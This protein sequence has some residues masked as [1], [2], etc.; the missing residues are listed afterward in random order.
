[1]KSIPYINEYREMVTQLVLENRGCLSASEETQQYTTL[2]KCDYYLDRTPETCF[3]ALDDDGRLAG[4]L[5]GCP[6]MDDYELVFT[7]EYLPKAAALSVRRYVEAKLGL[8]PYGMFRDDFK[9]HFTVYVKSAWVGMGVE[10]L[11]VTAV[12]AKLREKHV[13]GVVTVFEADNEELTKLLKQKGFKDQLT[14]KFGHAMT[15]SLKEPAV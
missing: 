7:D 6:D 12:L 5:L 2:T 3:L 4:C 10:D 1:M 11:L 15:L 14:T 13:A 8:L 9:A